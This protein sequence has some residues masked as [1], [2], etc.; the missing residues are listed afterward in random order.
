MEKWEKFA[1]N[2]KYCSASK[3]E[4]KIEECHTAWEEA[5]AHCKSPKASFTVSYETILFGGEIGEEIVEDHHGDKKPLDDIEN[6][7]VVLADGEDPNDD[8]S[9]PTTD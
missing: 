7:A 6:E 1:S 3:D 8:P 2:D 4:K 9:E 5:C